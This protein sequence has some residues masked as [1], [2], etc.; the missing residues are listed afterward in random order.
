MGLLH[1]DLACRG[2]QTAKVRVGVV[3]GLVHWSVVLP[4]IV[5]VAVAAGSIA[6]AGPDDPPRRRD[7]AAPPDPDPDAA[8]PPP[9]KL[10]SAV[11]PADSASPAD[12]ARDSGS[13]P[14]GA[15]GGDGSGGMDGRDGPARDGGGGDGGP[16][17]SLFVNPLAP[18]PQRLR[19]TGLFTTPVPD[20]TKVHPKAFVFEPRYALW[21]NGLEKLRHAVIPDNQKINT[22]NREVWDFPVG[23]MFFKTFLQ[24]AAADGKPRPVE[25]RLIRRIRNTGPV[26]DQWEFFAYQWTDDHT[27][28]TLLTNG[29]LTVPREVTIKGQPVTHNIPSTAH[30]RRCHV[31]NL[32]PVIGFDELRLNG[33][34]A[35][36]TKTQLQVVI[37]KGWLS[38]TPTAPLADVVDSNPAQKWIREYMHGN[39]AHCHNGGPD[40]GNIT[41]E[42]DLGHRVFVART[43]GQM[44][45]GRSATGLRVAPGKPEESVLYLA[46]MRDTMKHPDLKPMPFLGVDVVDQDAAKRLFDWIRSLPAQ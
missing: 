10:D 37:E 27:D 34:L 30:C 23:T 41:R 19:D 24:D 45:V 36:S 20:L 29:N 40:L 18:I 4:W 38:S 22:S 17:V 44:V 5:L 21:S 39:C 35:G 26:V 46:F 6:C 14:D 8:P 13:T 1:R 43:V 42:Y 25:T 11:A 16:A 9:V 7:S 31:G 33:R 32:T 28:A 12:L 15:A 2:P 3:G